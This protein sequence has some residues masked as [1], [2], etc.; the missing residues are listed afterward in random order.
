MDLMQLKVPLEKAKLMADAIEY[1][2][3][4]GGMRDNATELG[5][6]VVWLRYRIQRWEQNHPTQPAA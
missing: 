6:I 3:D 4:V 1:T 2:F 5:Q